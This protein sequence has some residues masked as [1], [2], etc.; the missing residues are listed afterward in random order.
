VSVSVSATAR[1]IAIYG[2]TYLDA[3]LEVPIGEL[4]QGKGKVD[5][6]VR[7]M[8]GG[9]PCN[10]A[11]ALVGRLPAEQVAIVTRI[12]AIDLARLRAAVPADTQLHVVE[13]DSL[14]WPPITV[15][16]NPAD[17]CRLLRSGRAGDLR[18]HDLCELPAA[19]VHVF[20]RVDASLV[21]DVRHAQ[22][23]ARLAWCAG[24]SA[25]LDVIDDCDLAC[26]NTAEA[27]TL[28][29]DAEAPTRELAIALARR[30]REGSVRVVTGR[31]T[32]PTVAAIREASGV[33]CVESA[34]APIPREQIRR[35]L[36]VGDVFAARFVVEATLDQNGQPHAEMQIEN[37][38]A[39]A[40]AAA[41][42]FMVS[43]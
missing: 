16:F 30:A 8:F 7:A 2:R 40:Q 32:A 25:P 14:D 18:A 26:V 36:R 33:R 39:A 31:G 28:T 20:G 34:P 6:E 10:A 41:G 9:F 37:A 29:G 17:E 19:S 35:L 13:D 12:P 38:L 15:I 3:E 23:S 11:R 22:P 5:V 4:A 24:A 42:A 43:T 1:S 21:G 27:R